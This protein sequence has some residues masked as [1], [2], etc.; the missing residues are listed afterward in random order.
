MG[1]LI[2]GLIIFLGL[3]SVRIVADDWRTAQIAA[4]GA[5]TWKGLYSLA[6]AVGLGLIV[7]GYASAR[8]QPAVLW[9]APT[10]ARHLAPPLTLAAFIF[11]AAAYVPRNSIKARL[12]HPMVL[13]I[14]VWAFAHLLANNTLA[15]LLLFGGFFLWAVFN[16]RSA[17]GRDRA[18]GTVYPAGTLA[19]T[20]LAVAV[21]I[22][23]WLVFAAWLHR[24]V[25]GVPAF[26]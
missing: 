12:H 3:H 5:N 7:W 22:G 10:W 23:A 20:L 18:A 24:L 26:R 1:F 19:A 8:G 17:R 6:S 16:F 11:L 15:D 13:G 25:I 14:K 21:G 4:R 2:L 9:D